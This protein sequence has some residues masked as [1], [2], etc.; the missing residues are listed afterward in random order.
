M[1]KSILILTLLALTL[2]LGAQPNQRLQELERTLKE[3]GFGVNHSQLTSRGIEHRWSVPVF[4]TDRKPFVSEPLWEKLTAEEARA[5]QHKADSFRAL[6]YQRVTEALGYIRNTFSTLSAEAS[7]SYMY[8][9]HNAGDTIVYSMAWSTDSIPLSS[10]RTADKNVIYNNAREA[11]SFHCTRSRNTNSIGGRYSHLYIEPYPEPMGDIKSFDSETYK[12]TVVEP[13]MKKALRLKGARKYPVYWRHDEG[14]DADVAKELIWKTTLQS[15]HGPN[16]HTGLTTGW[17]YFIPK[18]YMNE[19]SELLATLDSLTYAYVNQHYDQDYTYHFT[20]QFSQSSGYSIPLISGSNWP[21]KQPV[22]TSY[23][24]GAYWDEDGFYF[25]SI[26]TEG[27]LWM[28]R[29]YTKL[30]SWVNGERVLR[31]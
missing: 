8:E 9:M 12:T 3:L 13:C 21:D 7:E 19:A 5:I 16:K 4:L 15:D 23:Q 28:P 24:L 10:W 26:T 31:K 14:Y 29:D 11:V 25:T 30:K 18:A 22:Q 20:P 2:T 6:N 17:L 1:K 27:E